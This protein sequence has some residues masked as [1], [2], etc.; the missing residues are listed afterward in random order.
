MG[1]A[2]TFSGF[3]NID[4]SAILNAISAQ[5]RLPVQLLEAEKADLQQQKSAFG[6]LASRLAEVEAASRDL[7][8]ATAFATTTAT[9][10]N[11]SAASVSSGLGAIPGSYEVSITRLARA[12]VTTTNGAAPD[13]DSTIVASGGTLTIGGVDVAVTGDVTLQ[14]LATTI[15]ETDGIGVTASVVRSGASYV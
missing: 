2:I 4:F 13:A 15:N 5:D 10:S 12:Q 1:S 3:N 14:G 8:S 9:A 6:T 7:A 11:T